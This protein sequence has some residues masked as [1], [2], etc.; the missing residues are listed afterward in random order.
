MAQQACMNSTLGVEGDGFASQLVELLCAQLVPHHHNKRGEG[1]ILSSFP[2]S[3]NLSNSRSSCA[4]TRFAVLP[5][6]HLFRQ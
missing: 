3:G 2:H 6:W 1:S 5:D 4:Y